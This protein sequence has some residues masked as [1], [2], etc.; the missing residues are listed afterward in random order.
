MKS[1]YYTIN[2][3]MPGRL[4]WEFEIKTFKRSPDYDDSYECFCAEVWKT[5]DG[6]RFADKTFIWRTLFGVKEFRLKKRRPT[7]L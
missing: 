3:T 4:P 5:Y 6:Q 7:Y 1:R 2:A